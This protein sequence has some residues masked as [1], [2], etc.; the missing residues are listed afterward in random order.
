V[1]EPTPIRG[2]GC[3]GEKC[4]LPKGDDRHG[5][6]GSYKNYGCRCKR[7]RTAWAIYF[8][9]WLHRDPARAE[10]ERQRRRARYLKKKAET[11]KVAA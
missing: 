3:A 5:L 10:R 4:R 2:C 11:R 1:T 8:R 6:S 9:Q 7:C